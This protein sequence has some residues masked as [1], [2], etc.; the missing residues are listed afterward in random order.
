ML[1]LYAYPEAGSRL[2][3]ATRREIGAG[4]LLIQKD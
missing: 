1:K 3:R 2:K 4:K